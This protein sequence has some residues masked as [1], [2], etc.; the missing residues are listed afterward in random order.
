MLEG[1]QALSLHSEAVTRFSK[2][3]YIVALHSKYTR[4]LTL[5]NF[6]LCA[7]PRVPEASG[8]DWSDG[9]GEDGGEPDTRPLLSSLHSRSISRHIFK[10]T[11]YSKFIHGKCTGTDL[12]DALL[13]LVALGEEHH[14]LK[15]PLH[16]GFT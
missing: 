3:L 7:V 2:V 4:A 5:E 8:G 14:V 1:W 12:S 11:L 10:S 16:I 13:Q 15:S 9:D 6:F